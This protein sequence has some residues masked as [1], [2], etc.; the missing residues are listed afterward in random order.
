M[1]SPPI[2]EEGLSP[3]PPPPP[4]PPWSGGGDLLGTVGV[5][6][7]VNHVL[8]SESSG[9]AWT[10]HLASPMGIVILAVCDQTPWCTL[11]LLLLLHF[12]YSV[13]EVVQRATTCCLFL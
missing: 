4:P 1:R 9:V 5:E 13:G 3:S 10:T 12:P 11:W 2:R 7:G 8:F 6:P